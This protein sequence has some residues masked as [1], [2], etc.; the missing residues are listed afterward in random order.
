MKNLVYQ[1]GIQ[2]VGINLRDAILVTFAF[3]LSITLNGQNYP[4]STSKKSS[5]KQTV[6]VVIN[7]SMITRFNAVIYNDEN[8][9]LQHLIKN[10]SMEDI[11][12]I[13]QTMGVEQVREATT[14]KLKNEAELNK[15]AMELQIIVAKPDHK[16][17]S[18][19]SAK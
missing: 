18:V 14:E 10:H 16:I 19:T 8:A 15:K 7:E 1:I 17:N 3:A 9:G 6:N 12:L 4:D 5:D 11:A 2:V 13:L